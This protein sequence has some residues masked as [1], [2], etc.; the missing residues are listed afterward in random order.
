MPDQGYNAIN[1]LNE[2]ITKANA[3]MNHLAETIE[4]PVLGKQSIMLH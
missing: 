2:F 4:N 1:H 3:E